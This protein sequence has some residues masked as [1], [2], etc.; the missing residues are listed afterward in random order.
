VKGLDRVYTKVL[1]RKGSTKM[2]CT[3]DTPSR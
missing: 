3:Q 1:G 2:F